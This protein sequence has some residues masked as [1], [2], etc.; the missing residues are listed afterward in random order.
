[1]C[2][3]ERPPKRKGVDYRVTV[4]PATPRDHFLTLS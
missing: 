3:A 4:A 2:N 1:M